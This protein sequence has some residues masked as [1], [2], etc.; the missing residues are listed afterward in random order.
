[1][2]IV[3]VLD[4]SKVVDDTGKY[5]IIQEEELSTLNFEELSNS[6]LYIFLDFEF[7]KKEKYYLDRDCILWYSL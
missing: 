5:K 7:I 4:K 3:L 2:D 6:S 1:M